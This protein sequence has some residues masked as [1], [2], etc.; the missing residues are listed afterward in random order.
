MVEKKFRNK[1]FNFK[2]IL[3]FLFFC[4]FINIS[5]NF[6][7][8]KKNGFYNDLPNIFKTSISKQNLSQNLLKNEKN[9]I[10]HNFG[11]L[12]SFEVKNADK[13]I[14]LVGDSIMGSLS[15]DLKQKLNKL[16]YSF[17]SFTKSG[18]PFFA[19]GA[20]VDDYDKIYQNCNNEIT[21]K[22]NNFLMNNE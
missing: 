17:N 5:L 1:D 4:F 14:Y 13:K 3:Y 18:C 15:F 7:F 10:C 2:K 22:R 12:C 21:F 11:E 8:I 6:L 16:N 9:K 20:I 19:N